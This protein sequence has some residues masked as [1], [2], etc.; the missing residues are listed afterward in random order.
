MRGC[1]ELVMTFTCRGLEE[2][3]EARSRRDT[4]IGRSWDDG[5]GANNC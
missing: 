1:V 2:G 4:A 5:L 3:F